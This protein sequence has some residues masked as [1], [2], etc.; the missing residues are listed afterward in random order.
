MKGKN[1]SGYRGEGVRERMRKKEDE[2]EGGSEGGRERETERYIQ[3]R[4]INNRTQCHTR[5]SI[6][7]GSILFF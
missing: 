2:R 4:L 1:R 6:Q 3:G 5:K 7:N